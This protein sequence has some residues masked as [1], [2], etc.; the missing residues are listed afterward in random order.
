MELFGDE[1]GH[2]RSLLKGEED[3]FVLGVVAGNEECCMRCPKRAVRRVQDIEEARWND[4]TDL[5]RRRL[6]DCLTDCEPSLSFGYVAIQ[7]EDLLDL[8]RHYRLYEDDLQYAWD[9]CV[10]G[11]C[12]AELVGQLTSGDNNFT[13][14]FD[15]I[16]S[17]KMSNRV[18]EV[19]QETTRGLS[20]QHRSSRKTVG[21]QTADCFA[22]AV[23]EHLLKGQPWLEKF[24]DVT[25]A[26]GFALACVERRLYDE[27]PGP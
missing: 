5:Q 2:L 3:I 8:D 14:T 7:R 25:C 12:Y 26:T 4:L 6:I 18:T 19:I 23:R 15:R 17:K 10:I 20:V 1:S 16:F 21:I 13:F 27:K 22:G 24:Q 11:D 9:L